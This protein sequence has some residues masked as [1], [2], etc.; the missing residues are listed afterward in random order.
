MR[1]QLPELPLRAIQDRRPAVHCLTNTVVQGITANMLLALGAIPSMSADI[2]E[3][4][5]FVRGADALLVNLGTLDPVRKQAIERAIEQ[6]QA[7]SIPWILDPVLVDRAPA[8]L[9]Y[10]RELLA[11][12]PTVIRGNKGEIA[13]LGPDATSLA[14]SSGAVVAVT[15]A[16]DFITDGA[17]ELT[18]EGGHSLMSRVTGIGCA[19][20]ALIAAFCA[21]SRPD[22]MFTAVTEGLTLLGSAGE[23]AAISNAGPGGFAAAILD[24]I[25]QSSQSSLG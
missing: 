24:Q 7:K 13:A 8:R 9:G 3:V 15:G 2:S 12:G 16:T 5:D 23:R 22:A 21:V 17:R 11:L 6:A 1:D 18:L 25:Y 19:G 20:T 14:Q 10:A 4:V